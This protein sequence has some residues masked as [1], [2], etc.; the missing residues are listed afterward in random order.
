MDTIS[1]TLIL[2]T[3]ILLARK[4]IYCCSGRVMKD[5]VGKEKEVLGNAVR[6]FFFLNRM[7]R[8]KNQSLFLDICSRDLMHVG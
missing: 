1:S 3:S 8:F 7:L 2:W 6:F 5:T 4:V